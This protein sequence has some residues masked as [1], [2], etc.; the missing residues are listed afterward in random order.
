MNQHAPTDENPYVL[1]TDEREL[2]RLSLQHRLWSGRC[3]E[4]WQRAG[5]GP[6]EPGLRIMDL[7]CGPGYATRDLAQMLG[8]SGEIVAVDES[9]GFVEFTAAAELAPGSA[10]V[11]AIVGDAMHLGSLGLEPASLDGA[12]MRWVV[13]FTPDRPA[14]IR[15]LADLIKP[16]GLLLIQDYV[17]W[18]AFWWAP[19]DGG[20]QLMIDRI[21]SAYRESETDPRIGHNILPVLRDNGFDVESVTP[22][23]RFATPRDPLW[24]W[25]NSY[26]DSFLPRLVESGHMTA[27][28]LDRITAD[29]EHARTHP[30][31]MFMSPPQVEIIAHRR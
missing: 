20:C 5:W 19:T 24:A 11:N 29:W 26:F 10:H 27:D 28:E 3:L 2:H 18:D 15:G 1:G 23:V 16:G 14:V 21:L 30:D 9:K 12:Y 25:P 22:V 13:H 4:H 6:R 7:G 17:Q 8:R 31:A